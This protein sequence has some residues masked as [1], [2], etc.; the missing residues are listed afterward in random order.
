M[1]TATRSSGARPGMLATIVPRPSPCSTHNA[2]LAAFALLAGASTSLAGGTARADEPSVSAATAATRAESRQRFADGARALEEGRARDALALFEEA[3]RLYPHHATLYNIGLC[4]R[5]LGRPVRA[6]HALE[7]FLAEGGAASSQ[8]KAARTVLDEQRARI[9][10]LA[11]TVD[12]ADAALV[13]DE[14]PIGEEAAGGSSPAGAAAVTER[15]GR[16]AVDPGPH[17]LVAHAPGRTS[18]EASFDAAPG[19]TVEVRLALPIARAAAV[20]GPV[21]DAPFWAAV[22]TSAAAL[23][24]GSVTG[25]IALGDS[26]AYGDPATPQS[27]AQSRKD[28]GEVLRVVADVAFGTALVGAAVAV[29]L[30]T[31]REPKSAARALPSSRDFVV[32]R[33]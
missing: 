14:T 19:A 28:R 24:T 15:D 2:L 5:A 22:G 1:K 31:V 10:H 23:V 6:V 26:R 30:A 11:A 8:S 13:L 27:E 9:A 18:A 4:H 21:L 25:A 32:A 17:R 16:L 12:P 3:Y 20:R 33:F 29:V 7:R